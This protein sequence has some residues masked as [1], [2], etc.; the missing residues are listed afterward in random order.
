MSEKP[1][2]SRSNLV[3]LVIFLIALL[4]LLVFYLIRHSSGQVIHN[5]ERRGR[6]GACGRPG[7]DGK[8]GAPGAAGTAG[9]DGTDGTDGT[10]G[11]DGS[12]PDIPFASGAPITVTTDGLGNVAT[13]AV[14]GFGNSASNVL[15]TGANI[16]LSGSPG[17]VLNMA[18]SLPRDETLNGIAA[19]FSLTSALNLVGTQITLTAQLYVLMGKT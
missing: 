8:D 10:D 18:R 19:C 2:I 6:N 3:V 13:G 14:V 15:F 1:S 4:L 9:A 5:I 17:L 16:D 7:K 11:L 12:G